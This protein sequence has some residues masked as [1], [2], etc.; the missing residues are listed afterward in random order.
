MFVLFFVI[1]CILMSIE[2]RVRFRELW[3]ST[4]DVHFVPQLKEHLCPSLGR[5]S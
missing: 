1:V 3:D 2:P 5:F 4:D